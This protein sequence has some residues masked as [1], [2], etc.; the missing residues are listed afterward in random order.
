MSCCYNNNI[1]YDKICLIHSRHPIMV[2]MHSANTAP[3][4]APLGGAEHAEGRQHEELL[5]EDW[6]VPNMHHTQPYVSAKDNKHS[7]LRPACLP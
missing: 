7:K 3:G 4:Y 5:Q 1:S 6:Q 2:V